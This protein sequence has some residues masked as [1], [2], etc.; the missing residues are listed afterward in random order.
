[1]LGG[2]HSLRPLL[3]REA[4]GTAAAARL[5]LQPQQRALA[6]AAAASPNYDLVVIGG[7]PGGYVAAIKAAQLGMKVRG[8]VCALIGRPAVRG[9][10]GRPWV[11]RCVDEG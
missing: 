8:S 9:S 2:R 1:M 5:L 7:G 11:G 10:V 3:V 6:A 4:R